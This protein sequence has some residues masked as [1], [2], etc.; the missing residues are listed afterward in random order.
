MD[1]LFLL[2]GF[3]TKGF[4]L[5]LATILPIMNP[6]AMAPTFLILT[7][8]ANASTRT[9]LARRIGVNVA[10]L[11]I[12]AMLVGSYILDIFGIS[13]PIVR[14]GGGLIVVSA[15]WKMLSREPS[16]R[17]N[18][19]QMAD[20]FTA[21]EVR[22]RAFYPMTFPLSCGPGSI[23][24]ALT[25]GAALYSPD[26]PT[27]LAGTAGSVFA[28]LL[29]GTLVYLAYRYARQILRPLGETGQVVFL[30]LSAFILLCVGVQIVWDGASELIRTLAATIVEDARVEH[31]EATDAAAM[32][33]AMREAL[34]AARNS[35]I[36]NPSVDK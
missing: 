8:G 9:V 35:P 33:A 4:L 16:T 21:A 18:R 5:M 24:A 19:Q 34:E 11:L 1:S 12:G 2:F 10:L 20:T 28:C 32:D 7:E 22:E 6:L 23:A 13:L 36:T 29:M 25:V 26:W 17:D 31:I 27:R 15:S 3:L 14:V 30:R